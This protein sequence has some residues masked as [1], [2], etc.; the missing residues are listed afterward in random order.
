MARGTLCHIRTAGRARELDIVLGE[1][2]MW[3]KLMTEDPE[4]RRLRIQKVQSILPKADAMG[5]TCVVTHVGT[6]DASD[7]SLAPH[8]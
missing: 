5:V 7:H 8:S 2:G 3:E 4:L 1:W 6:R